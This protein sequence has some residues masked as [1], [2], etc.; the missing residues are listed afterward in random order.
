MVI[1][2]LSLQ[3]GAL[4]II[5]RKKHIFKLAQVG[6]FSDTISFSKVPSRCVSVKHK[7]IAWNIFDQ[8]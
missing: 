6:L 1:V 7:W 4:A 8:N 3:S 5:D 2:C